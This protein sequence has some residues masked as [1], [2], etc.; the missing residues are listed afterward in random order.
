MSQNDQKPDSFGG[1][2]D[3]QFNGSGFGNSTFGGQGNAAFNAN[4]SFGAAG[5]SKFGGP[6]EFGG[7]GFGGNSSVS[8]IFNESNFSAGEKRKRMMV[9]G[10]AFLALAVVGAAVYFNFVAPDAGL[11]ATLVQPEALPASEFQE[12]SQAEAGAEAPA[13]GAAAAIEGAE[14]DPALP[15]SESEASNVSSG[16]PSTTSDAPSAAPTGKVTSWDYDEAKGGPVINVA[17]GAMV[18]VAR[19][20]SFSSRYVYGP[21]KDGTFRIPNPPPGTIYWREQG[22]AEV[23][24]IRVNPPPALSITFSPPSSMTPGSSLSWEASGSASYYRVE[25]ATDAG[26]LDISAAVSTTG[27]Q[28]TINGLSPGSYYVRVGGLNTAAGKFEYSRSSQISMQ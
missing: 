28:A 1:G 25:F 21:A 7:G 26:F 6:S 19:S 8:Q 17:R 20:S 16:A 22:A 10:V 11:D 13:D 12:P 14:D 3:S 9:L 4:A 2:S 27:T 23:N 5:N 24:E 15:S 18:E